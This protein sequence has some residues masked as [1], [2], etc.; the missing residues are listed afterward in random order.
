MDKVL[1][2]G[3]SKCITP[4]P[5]PFRMDELLCLLPPSSGSTH[6][7]KPVNF[8]VTIRRYIPEDSKLHTRRRENLNL[9][10][11]QLFFLPQ[12]RSSP[13]CNGANN[14]LPSLVVKEVNQLI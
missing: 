11:F 7:L 3:S 5:E 10:A 14:K 6:L 2:Q 8:N 1:K 4:S 12:P 13:K 9:T